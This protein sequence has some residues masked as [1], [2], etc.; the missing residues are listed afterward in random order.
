MSSQKAQILVLWYGWRHS[1]SS[2][3]VLSSYL[4]KVRLTQAPQLVRVVFRFL[5]TVPLFILAIDGITTH[6]H[7][8]NSNL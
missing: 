6:N 7:P 2:M 1:I 8:I 3:S 5:F 4:S